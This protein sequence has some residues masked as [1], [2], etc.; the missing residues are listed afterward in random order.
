MSEVRERPSEMIKSGSRV[1]DNIS[2]DKAPVVG[3]NQVLIDDYTNL[4]GVI[5]CLHSHGE[6]VLFIEGQN[7]PL[8]S[9]QLFSRPL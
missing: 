4:V 6:A 8:K 2:D 3:D 1:V 7:L 9:F 5:V